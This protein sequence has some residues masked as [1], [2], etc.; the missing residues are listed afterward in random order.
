MGI[1]ALPVL[2]QS[3][4]CFSISGS[5][6]SCLY[7]QYQSWSLL[8]FLLGLYSRQV[9]VT[10]KKA[11]LSIGTPEYLFGGFLLVTAGHIQLFSVPASHVGIGSIQWSGPAEIFLQRCS[12]PVGFWDWKGQYPGC[13]SKAKCH[14]ML[15][16][17][18]RAVTPSL[19]VSLVRISAVKKVPL[20]EILPWGCSISHALENL[21]Q[22]LDEEDQ[23]LA[24][25]AQ[26]FCCIIN[27]CPYPPCPMVHPRVLQDSPLVLWHPAL[28]SSHQSLLN[29]C[30]VFVLRTALAPAKGTSCLYAKGGAFRFYLT[31]NAALSNSPFFS[32]VFLTEVG[33]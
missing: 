8:R 3:V 15:L 32:H 19:E 31:N 33:F 12:I 29:Q 5:F 23:F 24:A 22:A 4:F 1:V 13:R 9:N 28:T 10:K 20:G 6:W 18:R 25:E 30:L 16:R 2:F 27:T 11:Q 21:I 17:S 7:A 26:L 14:L